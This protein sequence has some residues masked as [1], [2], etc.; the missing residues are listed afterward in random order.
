MDW[1]YGPM[2]HGSV[3]VH[4]GLAAEGPELDCRTARWHICLPRR[5]QKGEERPGRSSLWV[6]LGGAVID[7]AWRC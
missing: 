1:V 2:D 4:G 3:S 5:F 6:V 7:L